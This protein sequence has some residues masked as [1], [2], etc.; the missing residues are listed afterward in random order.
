[1]MEVFVDMS[2]LLERQK[3]I[4]DEY[5]MGNKFVKA[6]L[7][8]L[9]QE[10]EI[11]N[12]PF[13]ELD[14][15]RIR[16]I[17]DSY[18]TIRSF[19]SAKSVIKAFYLYL[20]CTDIAEQISHFEYDNTIQYFPA[21]F[22]LKNRIDTCINRAYTSGDIID[23]NRYANLRMCLYLIFFGLSTE[24]IANLKNDD[25]KQ[26]TLVLDDKDICIPDSMKEEIKTFCNI[27]GYEVLHR[28]APHRVDFAPSDSF[29]KM[30]KKGT[31]IHSN[32]IAMIISRGR[33]VIDFTS[34]DVRKSG[35]MYRLFIENGFDLEDILKNSKLA[36]SI[37]WKDVAEQIDNKQ[38]AFSR[39]EIFAFS[40]SISEFVSRL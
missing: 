10:C 9:Y 18:E 37:N 27:N 6:V 20:Q 35:D 25:C 17:C 12:L 30:N 19:Y 31:C 26:G 32:S 5:C 29:I 40:D 23:A 7:N 8:K 39:S 14:I 22:V 24:D 36:K 15:Q 38:C 13:D 34:T 16:S 33:N 4:L 3:A 1:M 2:T 28:D 11:S 21:F